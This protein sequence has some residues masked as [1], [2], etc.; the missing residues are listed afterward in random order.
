MPQKLAGADTLQN[1]LPIHLFFKRSQRPTKHLLAKKTFLAKLS[2]GHLFSPEIL[3]ISVF[4]PRM[5]LQRKGGCQSIQT[6]EMELHN[7]KALFIQLALCE[8]FSLSYVTILAIWHFLPTANMLKG[9]HSCV[10]TWSGGR[11]GLSREGNETLSCYSLKNML[12][13]PRY[14][15]TLPN[16]SLTF[17]SSSL[18]GGFMTQLFM[19]AL[20]LQLAEQKN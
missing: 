18:K 9:D 20:W 10:L 1:S 15:Q 12:S 6:A 13:W 17:G 11:T 16:S 4:P 5:L 2:K 7:P 14:R 19:M 3:C 8:V